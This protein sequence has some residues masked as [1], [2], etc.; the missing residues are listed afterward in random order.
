MTRKCL[1]CHH[2]TAKHYWS[3]TQ[4][5]N[6]QKYGL[7]PSPCLDFYLCETCDYVFKDPQKFPQSQSEK[8]NYLQHQNDLALEGYRQFLGRIVTE[9]EGEN[10]RRGGHGLNILDYGSGP[11]P[12]M[13]NLFMEKGFVAEIYDPY[14]APQSKVLQATYDVVICNEVVEHFHR[15]FEEWQKLLRLL[16]PQGILFISTLLRPPTLAEF[17]P[18]WY[19]RDPTHVGFYSE[20]VFRWLSKT[21]H[22]H[23]QLTPTGVIRCQALFP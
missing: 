17:C 9:V 16:K 12:S 5:L 3:Q 1:L 20:K 7:L 4:G 8:E 10:T 23:Y 11:V 19:H 15:P 22:L 18:W 6:W 13:Q 21:W 2:V 14:F